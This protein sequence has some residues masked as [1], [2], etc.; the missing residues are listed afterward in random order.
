MTAA[1][2]KQ[3]A[4][5]HRLPYA[6]VISHVYNACKKI[7][8]KLSIDMKIRTRPRALQYDYVFLRGGSVD[9]CSF[10]MVVL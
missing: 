2:R 10:A 5:M 3:S 1:S 6:P 8:V 9:L 4:D 7:V